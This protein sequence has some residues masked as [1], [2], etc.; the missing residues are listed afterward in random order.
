MII[1][2]RETHLCPTCNRATSSTY[3]VYGC[4]VCGKSIHA[5]SVLKVRAFW[6]EKTYS[7]AIPR[8]DEYH[9]CTWYCLLKKLPE[10]ESDN[11]ISLPALWCDDDPVSENG[12]VDNFLDAIKRIGREFEEGA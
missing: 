12:T 9:F 3:P 10:I 8:S 4:D 2:E 7:D 1:K 6:K 5:N 11:F